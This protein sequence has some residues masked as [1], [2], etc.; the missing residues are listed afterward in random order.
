MSAGFVQ[1]RVARLDDPPVEYGM[2]PKH[3]VR[4]LVRPG[5][6]AATDPFLALMEDWFARGTFGPHPHRG[7][8]TVS[9][10]IEGQVEHRDSRG[11][12]STIRAGDAQWMTAGRG[13]LHS[14]E[15]PDGVEVHSLQLW[16]NLPAAEKMVEP[17]YQELISA[18]LPVRREAGVEIVV[19]S[20]ASGEVVSTTTN[21]VPVVM[22]R[23]ALER[24]ADVR[25]ELP[26]DY[27]AFVVI[28][29]GAASIGPD[30]SSPAVRSGQIAWLTRADQ[31]RRSEVAITATDD[32]PVTAL[33]FAGRPVNQPVVAHGPFV[34][35]SE[36]Q[37]REAYADFKEGRLGELT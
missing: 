16:V 26:G 28:L 35:N 3:R 9:Y 30:R 23:I 29:D 37:I 12:S 17:R 5:D 19:F 18:T 33:L 20:G 11:H 34:M 2:G 22:L 36:A 10:V 25:Q 1:R 13:L 6:W 32:S 27:N 24:G 4:Q 21:V 15:A 8:E 14:E 31:D 7:I